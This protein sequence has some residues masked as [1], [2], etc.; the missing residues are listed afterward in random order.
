MTYK[1][2]FVGNTSITFDY[3]TDI[4]LHE[5]DC[6]MPLVLD[7]VYINMANVLFIEKEAK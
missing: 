4:D 3:K 2:M 6:N 1:I 5:I 7:N